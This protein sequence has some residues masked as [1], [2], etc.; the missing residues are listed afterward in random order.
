MYW[1]DDAGKLQLKQDILDDLDAVKRDEDAVVI[2]S[3]DSDFSDEDGKNPP[4]LRARKR[5][6]EVAKFMCT[7]EHPRPKT[8]SPSSSS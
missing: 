3:C 2:A 1:K 6:S 7:H 4:H 5:Y 8:P